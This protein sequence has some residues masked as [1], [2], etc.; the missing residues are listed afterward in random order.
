M[1]RSEWFKFL[2]LAFD[3]LVCEYP[4]YLTENAVVFAPPSGSNVV[5]CVDRELLIQTITMNS[6]QVPLITLSEFQ[7]MKKNEKCI[8]YKRIV[9][10][11]QNYKV[12]DN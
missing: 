3:E 12:D 6:D 4:T 7:N 5:D 10:A 8:T 11:L 1:S 2:K 9:S